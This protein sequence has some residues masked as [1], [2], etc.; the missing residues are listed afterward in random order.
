[1]S[2]G[3]KQLIEKCGL[4]QEEVSRLAEDAEAYASG[5][6]PKGKTRIGRPRVLDEN[7]TIVAFRESEEVILQLDRRAR[8]AGMSRSDYLRALIQKDLATIVG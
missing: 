5:N 3:D 2:L 1:M 8:S 7:S 4:T 6:W